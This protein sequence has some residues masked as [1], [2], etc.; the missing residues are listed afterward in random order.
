MGT[1]YSARITGVKDLAGNLMTDTI[2]SFTTMPDGILTPG[3]TATTIAD[4][5]KTLRIVVNLI[6][7]TQDDKNHG[8]V[9]PLGPDGKPS[10][11]GNIDIQDALVILRKVVGLVSW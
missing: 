10:P 5:L 1:A 6:P 7:P 8:D 11:D 2:W 9:A 3:A 4:A